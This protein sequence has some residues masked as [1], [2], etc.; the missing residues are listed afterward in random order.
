VVNVM[1]VVGGSVVKNSK[2]VKLFEISKLVQ[3]RNNG[4]SSAVI[5]EVRRDDNE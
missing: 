4:H 5:F 1:M 3:R 2:R